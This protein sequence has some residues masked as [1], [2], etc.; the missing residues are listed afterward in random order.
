MSH[1]N[2]SVFL[3]EHLHWLFSMKDHSF[4]VVHCSRACENDGMGLMLER[5]LKIQVGTKFDS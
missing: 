3:D 5:V 1:C 4:Y 2:I